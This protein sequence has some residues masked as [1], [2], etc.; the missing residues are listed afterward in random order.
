MCYGSSI[1]IHFL[2]HVCRRKMI[3]KPKKNKYLFYIY[4]IYQFEIYTSIIQFPIRKP[5]GLNLKKI[6]RNNK[7][8]F[9]N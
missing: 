5:I 1:Q 9:H 6:T 2:L 7:L 8:V 4:I 3:N